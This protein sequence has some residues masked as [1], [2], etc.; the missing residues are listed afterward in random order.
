VTLWGMCHPSSSADGRRMGH[1][2]TISARLPRVALGRRG[3]QP[4][5]ARDAADSLTAGA[6]AGLRGAPFYKKG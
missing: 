6:I 4:P 5:V 3:G 2:S 1:R